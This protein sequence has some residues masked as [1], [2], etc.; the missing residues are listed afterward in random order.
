MLRVQQASSFFHPHGYPNGKISMYSACCRWGRI[1]L[2]EA[3]SLPKATE[4][5][6]GRGRLSVSA[7]LT[8][9]SGMPWHRAQP[10]PC[11]SFVGVSYSSFKIPTVLRPHPRDSCVARACPCLWLTTGFDSRAAGSSL[12]ELLL[13]KHA[14]HLIVDAR[15]IFVGLKKRMSSLLLFSH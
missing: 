6:G 15:F 13:T 2:R 11:A 12:F 10:L 5:D 8:S 14:S 3:G 4:L 9:H 7:H 1:R